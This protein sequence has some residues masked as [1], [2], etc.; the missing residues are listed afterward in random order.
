MAILSWK[1][2]G[3]FSARG[4]ASAVEVDKWHEKAAAVWHRIQLQRDIA[5]RQWDFVCVVESSC[6]SAEF[7]LI[8]LIC[9]NDMKINYF[10]ITNYKYKFFSF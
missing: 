10:Q 6:H 4:A 3:G 9:S 5:V 8:N 1:L 7:Y 2:R